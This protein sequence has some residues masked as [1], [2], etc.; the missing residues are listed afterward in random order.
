[1]FSVDGPFAKM[2]VQRYN[3]SS[4]LR[5]NSIKIFVLRY[6]LAHEPESLNVI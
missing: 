2:L 6:G 3:N 5:D 4:N 1:M